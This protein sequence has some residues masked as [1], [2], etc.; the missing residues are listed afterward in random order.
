[1]FVLC[2]PEITAAAPTSYC[3]SLLS[4]V[5]CDASTAAVLGNKQCVRTD[6]QNGA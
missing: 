3:A 1:M 4:G 6:H 2:T 5:C